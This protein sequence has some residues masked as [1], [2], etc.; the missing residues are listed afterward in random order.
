MNLTFVDPAV[1]TYKR[2]GNKM[3]IPTARSQYLEVNHRTELKVG[4]DEEYFLGF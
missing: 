4:N 1:L 2:T 3:V